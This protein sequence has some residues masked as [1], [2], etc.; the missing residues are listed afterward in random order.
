MV[1][2][3]GLDDR[4]VAFLFKLQL[5][6]SELD[7]IARVELLFGDRFSIHGYG[8]GLAQGLDIQAVGALLDE[9]LLARYSFVRQLKMAVRIPADQHGTL[10]N[11]QA[12]P[13]KLACQEKQSIHIVPIFS[14]HQFQQ[15]GAPRQE[16]SGLDP[17]PRLKHDAVPMSEKTNTISMESL[18]SLCKRRGFI[19][20][21]SEIYG[22][23]NGFW[24]YGPLGVEL[25]R[26]IKDAWWHSMVHDRDDIE[27]LDCSIIMHPRVWEASGHLEGFTDPMV[28]CKKCKGRWRADQLPETKCPQGGPHDY[29]E[30]RLFNL[31]FKTHAGPV[32]DASAAVYLRPETA[33]GIFVQFENVLAVS[34]QKVPFGIAQIGKA[35]RNEINPRNYTFRSREFEQMELEYF[36]KPGT[37]AQWHEYWVNER[38]KWY[39]TIGLPEGHLH[40]YIYKKEEL[41][42]YASAC[43]DVMYDFPFGTQELE[44]IAARGDFDLSRHA[45]FSG[46]SMEYFDQEAN[47]KFVPHVVEPSAGVDRI[48]LALLCEAFYEEW[49]PAKSEANAAPIPA[50]PGKQPPPGYEARTVMRFAPNIAPVKIAVFPLLKNKPELVQKA[51]GVFDMLR[52]RW[53][54]FWDITG[55]IGR[56][57]RRQDEIGTPYGVTVDFQTLEDNTVTLRDRDTMQQ[58]RLK[59]DD[60]VAK[61]AEKV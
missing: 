18:A 30:A 14:T 6:R 11:G 29:T 1:D 26:N 61:I 25:K 43:V 8:G 52:K 47:E 36:I 4:V 33:Q 27:G 56:R 46:K 24:D 45:Q 10:L 50:E 44:G 23:I 28:D 58:V 40:K 34:R 35:F 32:E 22:G 7:P 38:M 55:A 17:V 42:H 31:M 51:R 59:I 54:A 3:P 16:E 9:C 2:R 57:Y 5:H 12:F 15:G 49:V 53:P 20:Q 41:A 37:D 48:A 19:F 60:L 21:S 39:Q 13:L